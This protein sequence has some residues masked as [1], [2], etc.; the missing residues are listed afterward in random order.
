MFIINK[1]KELIRWVTAKVKFRMNVK[2]KE[3]LSKDSTQTAN[4][5]NHKLRIQK[6]QRPLPGI[7]WFLII[8][9]ITLKAKGQLSYNAWQER[10]VYIV[11][12]KHWYSYI[13]KKKIFQWD[14]LCLC[15]GRRSRRILF[16][17]ITSNNSRGTKP[18]CTFCE[19][20]DILTNDATRSVS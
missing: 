16:I 6:L 5:W 7:Q 1:K 15:Q 2:D 20:S 11:E 10:Q 17:A 3:P 13:T 9:N 12:R 18:S 4:I 19:S 14:G 8:V